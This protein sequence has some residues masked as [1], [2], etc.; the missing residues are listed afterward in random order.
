MWVNQQPAGVRTIYRRIYLWACERLYHEFAW[1]YDAVAWSVSGGRW[2][3]WRRSV[4][5]WVQ[6]PAVLEIGFGTGALLQEM[7]ESGHAVVGV[8][9][10]RAMVQRARPQCAGRASVIQ[11]PAQALP[12]ADCSF[13]SV[14]A[15][16][17]A[18]YITEDCTIAEVARVLRPAGRL[19]VGGLWVSTA[20]AES[21]GV[22]ASGQRVLLQRMGAMMH[23]VG[24]ALAITETIVGGARVGLLV[25]VKMPYESVCEEGVP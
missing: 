22:S 23:E 16:F 2:A 18:P 13:D 20:L 14:V 15:T 5:P 8:D 17:P 12:V 25:A 7:A 10:S 19:I 24:L 11:A 4:L 1:S 6:G 3:A 9:A 21:G